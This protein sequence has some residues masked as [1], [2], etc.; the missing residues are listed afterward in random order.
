MKN[1]LLLLIICLFEKSISKNNY[2]QPPVLYDNIS[3]IWMID[4]ISISNFS[5]VQSGNNGNLFFVPDSLYQI[6]KKNVDWGN[7]PNT[8]IF[9]LDINELLFNESYWSLQKNNIQVIPPEYQEIIAYADCG[10]IDSWPNQN[11][12][13]GLLIWKKKPTLFIRF[14]MRGDFYNHIVCTIWDS[15]NLPIKFKNPY[16]YYLV[17]APLR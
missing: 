5:V 4:T 9:L 8:I 17:Y 2:C 15:G 7:V 11:G 3:T 16:S 14:F 6:G 10:A 12:K 1:F 13:D